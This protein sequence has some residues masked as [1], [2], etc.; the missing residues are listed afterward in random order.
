M[1]AGNLIGNIPGTST[2]AAKN[3][4]PLGLIFAESSAGR[5]NGY[6]VVY[7][8]LMREAAGM[9]ADGI[10]NVSIAPVSGFFNRTWSGSALAVR[11][12]E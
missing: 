5:R 11:Y 3:F 2:V 7:D 9:E 8:A 10:I 4:E 12:L 1:G 6:G